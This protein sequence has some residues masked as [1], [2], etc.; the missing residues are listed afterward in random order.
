GGQYG[1]ARTKS[2]RWVEKAATTGSALRRLPPQWRREAWRQG[3]ECDDSSSF[4]TPPVTA[5]HLTANQVT[6][7]QPA[8]SVAWQAVT[9]RSRCQYRLDA[10]LR[11]VGSVS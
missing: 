1:L 8:K 5:N 7:S 10:A 2:W 4:L 6:A 9:I 11:L 3:R